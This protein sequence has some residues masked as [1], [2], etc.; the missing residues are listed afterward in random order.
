VIQ[1]EAL[2]VGQ[3]WSEL[4]NKLQNSSLVYPRGRAVR[5]ITDVSVRI[6]DASQNILVNA[7]RNPVYRFMVAEWLWI[8][9]GREDVASIVQYNPHLAQFS[10]DGVR[11]NGAYG[12]PVTEQW[13]YVLAKLQQDPDTRQAVI[14]IYRPPKIATRDVPCTISLQFLLRNGQL[15]TIATMRSSDIWLGL[16]YDVWNFTQLTNILAAQLN[17]SLGWITLHLGSSH[18]YEHD[19]PRV[20]RV[21]AQDSISLRSPKFR[22]APPAELETS[23]VHRTALPHLPDPWYTYS[24][25]FSPEVK[26]TGALSLLAALA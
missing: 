3:A 14:S 17:V 25:I 21:L 9:Y 4:L 15:N 10:D 19:Q 1:I 26:N 20:D 11:F 16:P 5:E 6:H 18:L 22:E 23:F 7:E 24:L 12:P 2:G 13:P 8:W